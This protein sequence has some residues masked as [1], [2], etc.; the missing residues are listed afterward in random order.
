MGG[1]AVEREQPI[2]PEQTSREDPE[3]QLHRRKKPDMATKKQRLW[4]LTVSLILAFSIGLLAGVSLSFGLWRGETPEPTEPVEQTDPDQMA[5]HIP[6]ADS[7]TEAPTEVV[8]EAPT[9]AVTEAPTEEATEAPTEEATEAP[10]EAP[11]PTYLIAASNS[12]YLTPQDYNDLSDW[13]LVLARNEIFARHGRK[14]SNPEIQ[15][16]FNGCDW[17][18]GTI[19]PEDFDTSVFNKYEKKNVQ[20]LKDASDAR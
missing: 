2:K 19:D 20:I 7:E 6:P 10:T 12:R 4:M 15:A 11:E 5:N 9:E 3:K 14:F 13:E 16:Y 17:Y 18:K 8:T 1:V